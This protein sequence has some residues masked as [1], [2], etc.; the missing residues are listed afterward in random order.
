MFKKI[1]T[2]KNL[3]I[4]FGVIFIIFVIASNVFLIVTNIKLD[5]R[6]DDMTREWNSYCKNLDID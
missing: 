4:F 3:A 6:L 2:I 5:Q 1:K